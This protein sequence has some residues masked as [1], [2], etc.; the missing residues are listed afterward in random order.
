MMIPSRVNPRRTSITSIL[1]GFSV[2]AV[3]IMR[4]YGQAVS[5]LPEFI[6]YI[7]TRISFLISFLTSSFNYSNYSNAMRF[8]LCLL[9]V[10][11]N[12]FFACQ[13]EKPFTSKWVEPTAGHFDPALKPFYH[14]VASGDPLPDRIPPTTP[15]HPMARP[16]IKGCGRPD[17]TRDEPCR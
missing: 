6:L 3:C 4:V 17:R 2:S 5:S 1:E 16:P 7:I 11:V 14:G 8:T 12:T 10:I 9:I 15:T 13:P